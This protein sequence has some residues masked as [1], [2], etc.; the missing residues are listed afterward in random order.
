MSLPH[1][2]W[3]WFLIS[4][5]QPDGVNAQRLFVQLELKGL[6]GL[7]ATL[8][9]VSASWPGHP[10]SHPFPSHLETPVSGGLCAGGMGG[11]VDGHL[12]HLTVLGLKERW[13]VPGGSAVKTPC[14]QSRRS[15]F[16]PWSGNLR[17]HMPHC[18]PRNLND[19]CCWGFRYAEY[20]LEI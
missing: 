15:G 9:R 2:I 12:W 20:V 6:R 3:R 10:L 17:S 14:F 4:H 16:D 7:W 5:F 11:L 18:P 19:F 13:D 8:L 1:G